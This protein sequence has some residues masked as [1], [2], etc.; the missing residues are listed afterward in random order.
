VILDEPTAELDPESAGTVR[1]AIGRLAA[2]RTVLALTHDE[3][4]A[5]DASRVVVL[6]AP[7]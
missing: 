5:A 1:E 3:E 7:G 6:E 2:G 4:L